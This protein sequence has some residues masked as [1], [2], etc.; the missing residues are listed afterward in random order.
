MISLSKTACIVRS[1][2]KV[3]SFGK[4]FIH[5]DAI[6]RFKTVKQIYPPPGDNLE[7]PGEVKRLDCGEVYDKDRT[8]L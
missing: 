1:S 2:L 7:I 6:V 4:K 5:N 8:R 3:P